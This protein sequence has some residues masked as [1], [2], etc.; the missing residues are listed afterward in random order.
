MAERTPDNATPSASQLWQMP[1]LML[2]LL[3]F[4][5]GLWLSKPANTTEQ[6]AAALDDAAAQVQAGRYETALETLKTIEP[7]LENL[8]PAMRQRYHLLTGDAI[9]LGQRSSNWSG[10]ID[11]QRVI[12]HYERADRFE[13]GLDHKHV[14]R[15]ARA[16]ASAGEVSRAL[17]LLERLGE[18]GTQPRQEL[19]KGAIRSAMQPLHSAE[20]Q[21]VNRLLD[22]LLAE[23]GLTQANEVWAT[24]RRA[25][26][27]LAQ[28]EPEPVIDTLLRRIARFQD[29]D[30]P[31][32]ELMV[33]LGRA[34]LKAGEIDNAERWLMRGRQELAQDDP[35][36]AFALLGLGRIQAR[37]DSPIEALE[38]FAKVVERFPQSRATPS[39]LLGKAEAEL[40]RGADEEALADY[41]RAVTLAN[42]GESPTASFRRELI[43]SLQTQHTIQRDRGD[44]ELALK[45]LER[46][47]NLY[48]P[49]S[50]PPGIHQRLAR[51]HEQL[52]RRTLGVKPDER[53]TPEDWHGL[54]TERRSAALRHY[55]AA[56]D[57]FLRHAHA[58]SGD[59]NDT[60]TSSLWRAGRYY[61]TAGLHKEAIEVYTEYVENNDEDPRYLQ[62]K[63]RLA[64]AHQANGQF[65][66]AIELYRELIEDHP[67]SPEAYASL[68]PLA[69]TYLAKGPDH[70]DRAEQ[71]LRSVVNDHPSLR[72]ESAEYRAAL[73][74]LGELYYRRGDRGD[75]ERA[76]ER[77]DEAIQRYGG[78]DDTETNP[79]VTQQRATQIAE[80]DASSDRPALLFK[81]ADAYR[82]SVQ[83]IDRELGGSLP[84]SRRAEL[85]AERARRLEQAKKRFNQVIHAYED[86]DADALDELAELYRR[87]AYFYRADCTY[88]LGEYEGPEG[89]IALY[90]KARQR[91]DDDPASLVALVQIVNAYAELGRWEDARR[92]NERAKVYLQRIP[93]EA[94]EDPNLP[95]NREHWQRWLDSTSQ[96]AVTSAA[97]PEA[98]ANQ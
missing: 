98:P 20:A 16:H 6:Y 73:I 41:E 19:L 59:D 49:D 14:E 25:E 89:A 64:R 47:R 91:Y 5:A 26:L 35:L 69:R 33:Q 31:L 58:A 10:P 90:Q 65:D 23:E 94:F 43:D 32:A 95:M 53:A 63:Q 13:P 61:D 38:H 24:A 2:S 46:E 78:E 22:R 74:E 57:A 48:R 1:V 62:A 54:S 85:E 92:A 83:Q 11:P 67:N 51:T 68:V 39:A 93:E 40:R 29:G 75:Y 82:K 81:L 45:L 66:Q 50:I 42:S 36:N 79:D 15:W 97:P 27:R 18:A 76:I 55:A 37:K 86:R 96:L 44:L 4:G 34:Y 56:A 60:Y 12:R 72:P 71:V 30:A 87:N 7:G 70:I 80:R 17:E 9:H 84:P 28:G 52:A 3:L 8:L 77:L 88:E 21:R